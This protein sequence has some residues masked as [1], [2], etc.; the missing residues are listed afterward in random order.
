MHQH[1]EYLQAE[2]ACSRGVGTESDEVQTLKERISW[3]E[4][5]NEDLCR[6]LC[7]YHGQ[8]ASEHFERDFQK[9]R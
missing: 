7:E 4:A 2:L 5:T 1:I 9:G 8:Q 3:L 6:K